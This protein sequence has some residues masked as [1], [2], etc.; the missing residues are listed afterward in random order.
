MKKYLFL[1]CIACTLYL[2][3]RSQVTAS[4]DIPQFNLILMDSTAFDCSAL[5]PNVNTFII[6]FSPECEHCQK[7]ITELLE[8]YSKF[9]DT[10]FILASSFSLFKIMDFIKTYNL[11][12]Y[13]N[14]TVA[15]EPDR[16][17]SKIYN[18]RFI[19]FVAIYDKQ[20]HLIM[21]HQGESKVESWLQLIN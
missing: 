5:K 6:H 2:Q 18:I 14:I 4:S 20:Q 17:F 13:P 7:E 3:G 15:Y 19:P 1:F 8:N 9:K 11:K 10:Q 21:S 16:I 12:S